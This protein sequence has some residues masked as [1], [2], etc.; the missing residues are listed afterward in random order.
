MDKT[1]EW[2]LVYVFYNLLSCMILTFEPVSLSFY[3]FIIY[4]AL[5]HLLPPFTDIWYWYPLCL[6]IVFI[7]LFAIYC[8]WNA[9]FYL[10]RNRFQVYSKTKTISCILYHCHLIQFCKWYVIMLLITW[11]YSTDDFSV[12]PFIPATSTAF[13]PTEL[14]LVTQDSFINLL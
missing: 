14:M 6:W 7:S 1:K 5:Y 9:V 10:A 3:A 11:Y 2:L 4:L 8:T 12:S 13:E